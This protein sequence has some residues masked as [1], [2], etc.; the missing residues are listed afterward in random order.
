MSYPNLKTVL[1]EPRDFVARGAVGF[2]HKELEVMYE[3][4]FQ[5]YLLTS[6]NEASAHKKAT[7]EYNFQV[8]RKQQNLI[9]KLVNELRCEH[10]DKVLEFQQVS[11][12]NDPATDAVYTLVYA[13]EVENRMRTND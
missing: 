1:Q 2:T 4:L 3:T 5:C 8:D 7:R 11:N 13:V 6:K 12:Y 10:K 9:E